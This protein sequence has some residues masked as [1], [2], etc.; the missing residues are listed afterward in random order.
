MPNP[1]MNLLQSLQN[2]AESVTTSTTY[3]QFVYDIRHIRE[4]FG[5]FLGPEKLTKR[6]SLANESFAQWLFNGTGVP[7]QLLVAENRRRGNP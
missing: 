1:V 6:Q 4:L 2:A 7:T 5:I 3:L